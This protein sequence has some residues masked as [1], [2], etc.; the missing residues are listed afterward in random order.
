MNREL[1]Y[2]PHQIGT[3]F[4]RHCMCILIEIF[5][6][7]FCGDFEKA[8]IS[9]LCGKLGEYRITLT[10]CYTDLYELR[11]SRLK[12]VQMITLG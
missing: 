10:S 8:N 11:A 6:Q 3:C 7:D 1:L 4:H 2:I 9:A 12:I 5:Y